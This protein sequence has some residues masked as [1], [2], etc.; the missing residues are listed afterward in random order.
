MAGP[1]SLNVLKTKDHL[2][3]KEV[4]VKTACLTLLLSTVACNSSGIDDFISKNA[5]W[6]IPL[7]CI[8]GPYAFMGIVELLSRGGRGGGSSGHAPSSY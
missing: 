3:P 5:C 8:G 1:N 7:L 6:V 4:A 2:S